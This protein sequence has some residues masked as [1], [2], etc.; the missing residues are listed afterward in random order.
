MRAIDLAGMQ[1]GVLVV[2]RRDP[3]NRRNW[4]C[5]CACGSEKSIARCNLKSGSTKSCGCLSVR[6][7]SLAKT[8]HGQAARMHGQRPTRTYSSWAAMNKRCNC[9]SDAAYPLYGGR[10]IT[11]CER[12]ASFEYFLADMGERP[13]GLSL[14][15]IDN[16][17]NYEPGNCKWGTRK[18]QGRNRRTSKFLTIE[19]ET[20]C[21]TEWAERNGIARSTITDR[22]A[23]GWTTEEAVTTPSARKFFKGSRPRL[24]SAM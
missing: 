15:R 19:G 6:W 23:R 20:L 3:T 8:K 13:P 14:E 9:E 17:G 21:M 16:D 2:L 18:E 24:A 1:Y 5:R 12:W 7:I 11:I 22:L 4:I 10:G